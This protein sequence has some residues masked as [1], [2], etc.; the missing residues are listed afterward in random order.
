[1]PFVAVNAYLSEYGVFED[2]IANPRFLFSG[3]VVLLY[4]VFWYVF[5]GRQIVLGKKWFAES[6]LA[7]SGAGG[8]WT[9]AAWLECTILDSAFML[10]LSTVS[11]S[12]VA[13][14]SVGDDIVLYF[15]MVSFGLGTIRLTYPVATGSWRSNDMIH[16]VTGVQ[17]RL[18]SGRAE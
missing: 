2:S 4:F 9:V 10:V 14:E 1:M 3:G 18:F 6:P 5:S 7:Q 12:F 15:V 17:A 13:L 16:R 11:F 8:A